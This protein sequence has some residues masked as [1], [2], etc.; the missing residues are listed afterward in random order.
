M[1][2]LVQ[3][4]ARPQENWK[5]ILSSRWGWGIAHLSQGLS[6]PLLLASS[7]YSRFLSPHNSSLDMA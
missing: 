4:K 6:V 1:R 5:V 7:V 2:I 3:D